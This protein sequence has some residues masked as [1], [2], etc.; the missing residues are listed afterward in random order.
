MFFLIFSENWAIFAETKEGKPE[1]LW[2][3]GAVSAET[4]LLTARLAKGLD[5]LGKEIFR[6][7]IASL[8]IRDVNRN[9]PI[10]SDILIVK[11][12]NFFFLSAQPIVT[13]KMLRITKAIESDRGIPRKVKDLLHG[14]LMGQALEAYADL[15]SAAADEQHGAKIDKIFSHAL[16][17]L[18]IAEDSGV[19]AKNGVCSFSGLDTSELI[20]LHCYLR[21]RFEKDIQP[22]V[23]KPWACILGKGGIPIYLVHNISQTDVEQQLAFLLTAITGY[24]LDVFGCLP[25]TLVFSREGL[26]SINLFIGENTIFAACNPFLL[27]QDTSFIANFSRLSKLT[28]RD[29]LAPTKAFLSAQLGQLYAEKMREKPFRSLV[30]DLREVYHESFVS[31]HSEEE[32]KLIK[33]KESLEEIGI[34]LQAREEI[35]RAEKG[36]LQIPPATRMKILIVGDPNVGKTA[37][38]DFLAGDSS[39]PEYILNI[40]AQFSDIKVPIGQSVVSTQI[41]DLVGKEKLEDVSKA[42]YAGAS[43]ALIVFDVTHPASFGTV[44]QWIDEIWNNS[45]EGAIPLVILGNKTDKRGADLLDEVDDPHA[46]DLASKLDEYCLKEYGFRISYFPVDGS[47]RNLTL[48]FKLLLFR[49]L[50]HRLE[51]SSIHELL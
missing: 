28:I 25:E 20:F 27:F 26:Q 32:V 11:M 35:S 6:E 38:K 8:R 33:T 19:M 43:G 48:A 45:K 50:L 15:Y 51:V 12:E 36:L 31:S 34:Q 3:F 24:S 2:K 42:F 9:P 30:E 40:N 1:I 17:E 4:A 29:I 41:W 47:G 13:A 37:I 23:R 39:V 10:S 46:F 21:Q 18:G 22:S 49:S 5:S 44:E 14:V 7:T 16:K